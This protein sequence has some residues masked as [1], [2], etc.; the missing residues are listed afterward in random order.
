MLVDAY[1]S[2]FR[3]LKWITLK[4]ERDYKDL[5]GSEVKGLSTNS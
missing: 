5:K 4:M 2:T 3:Q 1:H